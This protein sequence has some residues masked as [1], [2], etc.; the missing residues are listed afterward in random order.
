MPQKC[1]A[2]VVRYSLL[3]PNTHNLTSVAHTY[4][5]CAA[6]SVSKVFRHFHVYRRLRECVM[7][8]WNAV[9]GTIGNQSD[10]RDRTLWAVVST[11]L[12]ISSLRSLW[13][14]HMFAFKQFY[15]FDWSIRKKNQQIRES[16]TF[17][18]ANY[19]RVPY[20]MCATECY[21]IHWNETN[22]RAIQWIYD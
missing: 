17:G 6:I 9:F 5:T 19:R 7:W 4:F 14:D 10:D 22:A 8:Q 18:I 11:L 20:F 1:C 2:F 12:Q 13:L 15:S 16:K 21:R 3:K